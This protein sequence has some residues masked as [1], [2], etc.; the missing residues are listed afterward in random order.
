MLFRSFSS[1]AARGGAVSGR[2]VPGTGSA[3]LDYVLVSGLA[4]K[5]DR[6]EAVSPESTGGVWSLDPHALAKALLEARTRTD[7]PG[8]APVYPDAITVTITY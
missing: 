1:A 3:L 2:K 5:V 8:A 6:A 7:Q 4:G